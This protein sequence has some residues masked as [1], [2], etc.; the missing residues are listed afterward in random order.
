ML[1]T[2]L[3]QTHVSRRT[4]K[5]T[6]FWPLLLLYATDIAATL[7]RRPNNI[8]SNVEVEYPP[9]PMI[10]YLHVMVAMC[11]VPLIGQRRRIAAQEILQNA[12][13]LTETFRYDV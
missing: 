12:S 9:L 4:P 1:I 11:T 3:R 8:L 13:T 7:L 10:R 6:V 5:V 2:R